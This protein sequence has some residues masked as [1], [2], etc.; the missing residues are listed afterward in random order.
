MPVHHCILFLIALRKLDKI[1]VILSQAA[2]RWYER[3]A[4]RIVF[5][6]N[7]RRGKLVAGSIKLEV[8]SMELQDFNLMLVFR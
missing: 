6:D 1:T 4:G 3:F 8:L 5:S 7:C 2:L